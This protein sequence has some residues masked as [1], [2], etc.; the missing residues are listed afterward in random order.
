MV[1]YLVPQAR[2]YAFQIHITAE[3]FIRSNLPLNRSSS[4]E[5]PAGAARTLSLVKT[6]CALRLD[7][8]VLEWSTH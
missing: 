3:Q 1:A 2:S 8:T 7:K 5:A 4:Q 6:G